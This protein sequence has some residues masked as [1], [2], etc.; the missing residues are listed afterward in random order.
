MHA[1]L[2]EWVSEAL[3]SRDLPGPTKVVPLIVEASHRHFYRVS[4]DAASFVVMDS[5]PD[6]E[7]N[8]QFRIVQ[9]VFVRH[10]VPVPQILA[11]DERGYFLLTDLGDK[12]FEDLYAVGEAERCLQIAIDQLINIQ[13]VEDPSIPVYTDTRLRDE[14]GI[15]SEWFVEGL[16]QAATPDDFSTNVGDVLVANALDQPQCCIH[17]DY[18]CRNLLLTDDGRLGIV[19]FQ[20]ALIGPATYDLASLLWDC[21]YRFD[22]PTVRR[23][24]DYFAAHCRFDIATEN[25]ARSVDLMALQRQLKAVGIFARLHLRDGKSTHLG[26]IPPVFDTMRAIA[27]D[28]PETAALARWLTRLVAPMTRQIEAVTS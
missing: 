5:P 10:G 14:L 2:A 13:N 19:D 12:H 8:D 9:M 25:F 21:Y 3:D 20:D 17:R 4:R 7:Q 16:L 24:Q 15:F 18:H 27:D 1:T 26:Y 6:K 23:W 28:Y 11:E 22:V